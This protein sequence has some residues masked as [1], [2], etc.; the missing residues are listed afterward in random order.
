M[1]ARP[2]LTRSIPFWGL[3]AGS[4]VSAAVGA[5]IVV[6]KLALMES[7]LINGTQTGV[8]I[9][10]GQPLVGLG[11]VLIGAGVVGVLLALALAAA[12]SLRPA[13]AVEVVEPI[14]WTDETADE[15]PVADDVVV[16]EV[17][18]EDAAPERAADA[19]ADDQEP[20]PVR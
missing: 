13:A 6:D 17:V 4:V 15:Q 14:D 19:A 9:Y 3:L 2:S 12:A 16:E 1:T 5:W 18:V 11:A 7:A 8:E 10:L 20:Q